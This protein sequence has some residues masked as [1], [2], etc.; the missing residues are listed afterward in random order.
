MDFE[1]IECWSLQ[2]NSDHYIV[3]LIGNL[4]NKALPDFESAAAKITAGPDFLHTIVDMSDLGH[5]PII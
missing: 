4:T 3:K 5:L 1:D 2:K